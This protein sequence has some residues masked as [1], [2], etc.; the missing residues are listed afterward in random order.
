MPLKAT[1]GQR[2]SNAGEAFF[3]LNL[4]AE[5]SVLAERCDEC[6]PQAGDADR[7]APVHGSARPSTVEDQLLAQP[8][9]GVL[10]PVLRISEHAMSPFAP[11]VAAAKQLA[12]LSI[13]CVTVAGWS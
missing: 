1:G 2:V 8:V 7:A 11:R 6:M 12:D 3:F 13:P 4:Q 5:G 9:R 10:L